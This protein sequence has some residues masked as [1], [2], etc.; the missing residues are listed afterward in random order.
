MITGLAS[1]TDHLPE[2]PP[3]SDAV[4]APILTSPALAEY[5]ATLVSGC[6]ESMGWELKAMTQSLARTRGSDTI[7]RLRAEYLVDVTVRRILPTYLKREGIVAAGDYLETLPEIPRVTSRDDAI[8]AI[9]DVRTH[10]FKY[11]SRLVTLQAFDA[12]QRALASRHPELQ[13]HYSAEA[14]ARLARIGT[15]SL[16]IFDTAKRAFDEAVAIAPGAPLCA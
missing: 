7:E 10:L 16:W 3:P 1:P 13:A 5:V 14:A 9:D 12:A 4:A 15:S 8:T 2:T 6:G 11:D